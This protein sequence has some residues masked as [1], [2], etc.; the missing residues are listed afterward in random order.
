M[1]RMESLTSRL[2]IAGEL[3]QF[4]WQNKWWW[5]TPMIFVL[6]IFGALLIFAQSS[7]IAPF[8]YTLF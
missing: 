3:L 5:L 7:A 2:G 1:K 4:F 8:I 6:L